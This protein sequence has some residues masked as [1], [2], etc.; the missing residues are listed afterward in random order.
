MYRI[1]CASR[2]GGTGSDRLLTLGHATLMYLIIGR[3][4][5][6]GAT[7][8][9]GSNIIDALREHGLTITRRR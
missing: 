9:P 3:Y 7:S 2:A 1:T 8:W 4:H 5:V 6:H